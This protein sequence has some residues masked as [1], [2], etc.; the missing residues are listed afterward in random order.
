[1]SSPALQAAI[2]DLVTANRILGEE[3]VVDA[4]GHISVRHPDRLDRYLLARSRSP[5]VVTE[6]DIMEF[7]LDSNPIDQRGRIIY[8]ERF[9]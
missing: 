5:S 3:G 8:A 2:R 9:I 7:D 4:F 6:E 1:M